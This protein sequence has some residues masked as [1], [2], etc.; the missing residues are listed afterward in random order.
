MNSNLMPLPNGVVCQTPDDG[1]REVPPATSQ[2]GS[3]RGPRVSVGC[4]VGR[5]ARLL[6]DGVEFV[7][8]AVRVRGGGG[9]FL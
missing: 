1:D 8:A 4:H 5:G 3:R 6:S 7:A 2:G 9:G